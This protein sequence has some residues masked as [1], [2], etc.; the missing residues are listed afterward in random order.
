M[1]IIALICLYTP[2][3]KKHKAV[4]YP[5]VGGGSD[6]V[7]GKKHLFFKK[8]SHCKNETKAKNPE[9]YLVPESILMNS[10]VWLFVLEEKKSS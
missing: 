10:F 8:K 1:E 2:E 6:K 5:C 7:K 9:V 4:S 3:N